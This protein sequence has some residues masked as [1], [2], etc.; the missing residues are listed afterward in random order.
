MP[1]ERAAGD[2]TFYELVQRQVALLSSKGWYHSIELPDG[3]V[4]QGM[5]GIDALKS[6]ARRTA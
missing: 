2:P 1:A 5:I 6:S 4:I 3:Q